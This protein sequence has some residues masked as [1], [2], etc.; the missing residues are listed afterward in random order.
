MEVEKSPEVKQAEDYL[1]Q[2][3]RQQHPY[4][5][6]TDKVARELLASRTKYI[7]TALNGEM[8]PSTAGLF[9]RGLYMEIARVRLGG[10]RIT[11]GDDPIK[12]SPAYERDEAARIK[13]GREGAVNNGQA[14]EGDGDVPAETKEAS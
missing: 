4:R 7:E 14:I 8:C 5:I 11:I 9:E 3:L 12:R 1:V 6:R 2:L 13:A 10:D